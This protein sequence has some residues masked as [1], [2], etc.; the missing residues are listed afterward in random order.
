[1]R[2]EVS[3]CKSVQLKIDKVMRVATR[4]FVSIVAAKRLLS[5]EL[6]SLV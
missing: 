2:V 3:H 6:S 1:V 4:L 5:S